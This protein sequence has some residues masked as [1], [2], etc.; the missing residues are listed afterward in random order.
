MFLEHVRK[1]AKYVNEKR[2][3]KALIWDDMLRSVPQNELIQSGIG[4][5]VEPVIWVYGE[6]IRFFVDEWTY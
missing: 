5:L 3:M 4:K 6:N 2:N 1:V